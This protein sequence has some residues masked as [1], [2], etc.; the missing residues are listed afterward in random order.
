MTDYIRIS[1]SRFDGK[2]ACE[3]KTTFPSVLYPG[4]VV[5]FYTFLCQRSNYTLVYPSVNLSPSAVG[6]TPTTYFYTG[7]GNVIGSDRKAP[8]VSRNIQTP[9]SSSPAKFGIWPTLSSSNKY[10]VLDVVYKFCGESSTAPLLCSLSYNFTFIEVRG[11]ASAPQNCSVVYDEATGTSGPENNCTISYT[12][13]PMFPGKYGVLSAVNPSYKGKGQEDVR[14]INYTINIYPEETMEAISIP[15]KGDSLI[16]GIV[17]VPSGYEYNRVIEYNATEESIF[18]AEYMAKNCNATKPEDL[19]QTS[20]YKLYE[21][22]FNVYLMFK[23]DI[24]GLGLEN[25]PSVIS[26]AFYVPLYGGFAEQFINMSATAQ[27]ESG[28]HD[29]GIFKWMVRGLV[30]I[31]PFIGALAAGAL[32]ADSLIR[33]QKDEY[34]KAY[35][36]PKFVHE[37]DVEDSILGD[38]ADVWYVCSDNSTAGVVDLL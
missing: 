23:P 26:E 12:A 9:D 19:T 25:N 1:S 8:L 16:G 10:Y 15:S 18:L 11:Y 2:D 13:S 34:I 32:I 38:D 17:D 28:S 37:I 3:N 5:S 14:S 20:E 24:K 35:I 33:K 30:K 4:Q 36:R 7:Y 21:T 31:N 6:P 29:R 27:Q 22:M